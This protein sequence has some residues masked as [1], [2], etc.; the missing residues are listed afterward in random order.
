V[1]FLLRLKERGLPGVEFAVSDDHVGLKKA[2][3]E[4]L[5]EAARQRCYEH[6]LRNALEHRRDAVGCSRRQDIMEGL[7]PR[8]AAGPWP[9]PS[10]PP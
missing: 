7:P 6:R 2:G 5:T 10:K 8:R 4:L 1:E 3:G 9:N